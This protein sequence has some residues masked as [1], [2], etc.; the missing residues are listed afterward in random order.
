MQVFSSENIESTISFLPELL[1]NIWNS[2][3]FSS[4]TKRIKSKLSRY[5][6]Y[7]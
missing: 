3:I 6:K 7:R 2:L 4:N 5:N 1:L